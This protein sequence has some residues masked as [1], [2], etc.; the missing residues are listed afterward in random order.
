MKV[1]YQLLIMKRSRFKCSLFLILLF[2]SKF[3]ILLSTEVATKEEFLSRE[4]R[5]EEAE[6]VN[7]YQ[8]EDPD[9]YPGKHGL[10]YRD[11]SYTRQI[12]T[13]QHLVTSWITPCRSV[14]L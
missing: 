14:L 3:G 5:Q 4:V 11:D 8:Y 1:L 12:V 2:S 13:F 10:T 6:S 7:H 9:Y